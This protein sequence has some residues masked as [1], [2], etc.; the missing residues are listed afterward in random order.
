MK[1][2]PPLGATHPLTQLLKTVEMLSF[3]VRMLGCCTVALCG[4]NMYKAAAWCGQSCAASLH[5]HG[6]AKII[7]LEWIIQW[8]V[9]FFNL[10][11]LAGEVA[12]KLLSSG[13]YQGGLSSEPSRVPPGKGRLH[14]S[15]HSHAPK[16]NSPHPFSVESISSSCQPSPMNPQVSFSTWIVL[17]SCVQ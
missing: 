17:A 1:R 11:W 7:Y 14:P 6:V 10:Q 12:Q 16:P 8:L 13:Q 4:Q 15:K 2:L 9:M 3:Q 5:V